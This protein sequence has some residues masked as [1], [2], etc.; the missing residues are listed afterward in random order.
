MQLL[1]T[2]TMRAIAIFALI[3]AI[4]LSIA[5]PYSKRVQKTAFVQWLDHNIGTEKSEDAESAFMRHMHQLPQ[6]EE[7]FDHFV[8]RVS[9]LIA[10]NFSDLKLPQTNEQEGPRA[11]G[12]W[13]IKQ[14]TFQ[15]KFMKD[16]DALLPDRQMPVLKWTTLN[17]FSGGIAAPVRSHLNSIDLLSPSV[18]Q[19]MTGFL[20]P[21]LSSLTGSI[22]INAP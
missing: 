1:R 12:Q 17:T 20:K 21:V 15:Q 16:Q 4:G 18:N 2:H 5:A 3:L 11:L 8:M 10:S 7:S 22:S 19:W 6:Q 13:L 14:W 9:E